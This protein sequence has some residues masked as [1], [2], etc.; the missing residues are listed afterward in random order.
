MLKK[1]FK[2]NLDLI[3]AANKKQDLAY[4]AAQTKKVTVQA[5]K[6]VSGGKVKFSRTTTAAHGLGTVAGLVS[7]KQGYDKVKNGQV[8]EGAYNMVQGGAVTASEGRELYYASKGLKAPASTTG[9]VL[10]RAN[11]G[12]TA[13]MAAIDSKA[14]YEA[15]K[16]GNTVEASERAGS[17]VINAVSAFP[18]TAIVGAVGGVLDFAA[19][20]SGADEWMINKLNESQNRAYNDTSRERQYVAKMLLNT[21]TENL[22]HFNQKNRHQLAQGITGLRDMRQEYARRGDTRSVEAIDRQIGR[23]RQ[24]LGAC[25][26]LAL[27]GS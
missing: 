25:R 15:Y 14:T 10:G 12:L 22:R 21:P 24:G 9:K 23:I 19:A 17:A 11:M 6:N 7:V 3:A 27:Y 26:E 18:P 2:P 1:R 16:K 8:A 5:P 20:K 13:G 4:Q